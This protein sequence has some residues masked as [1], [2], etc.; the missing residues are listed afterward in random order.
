M[1][2]VDTSAWFAA[3]VRADQHYSAAKAWL[4]ANRR[5]LV[6]TDYVYD[7]TLTLL[8]RRGEFHCAQR[9]VY[10]TLSQLT[11]FIWV[12]QADVEA[13]ADVYF[14]FHDKGWSFTDCVS[15]VVMERRG[16]ASAFS[17]DQHFLQFGTVA[18]L[19]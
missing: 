8:R 10:H 17:F 14:R 4:T 16:I 12:T 19:P 9:W 18:V 2:F 13:A 1:I 11:E 15:R 6:T 3:C 5:R 7:E